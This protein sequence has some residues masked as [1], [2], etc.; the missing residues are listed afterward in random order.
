MGLSDL[1]AVLVG[2]GLVGVAVAISWRRRL[3]IERDLTIS[4]V[5]AMVQ[6]GAVALVIDVIFGQLGFSALFVLVM[7]GAATWTAG[8]RL[9]GVEG[10]HR[11]A[12]IAIG[13]SA[14]ITLLP[15]FASGAFELTPRYVI[16]LAGIVIGGAMKATSLAGLRLIDE[17]VDRHAEIEARLALGVSVREAM[18]PSLRRSTI[19]ALVPAIDQTKN[20]GL[21]S[22]PGAFVG[23]LL[24]GASPV[25]AARVQLT[26]LFALLGVEALAAVVTTLQVGR[27]AVRPGQRVEAPVRPTPAR[28]RT[29]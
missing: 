21:I 22:L 24:G 19:T 17:L 20:V 15:M 5:R 11:I 16:P 7:L 9:Q 23:M 14:A 29:G 12:G 3:G 8:G 2:L 26:V 27:S 10:R 25:D 6:L 4:T 28:A 18:A 13:G 1:S